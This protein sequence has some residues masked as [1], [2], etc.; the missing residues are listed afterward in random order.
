MLH[1]QKT[2]PKCPSTEEWIKK[3]RYMYTGKHYTI[4]QKNE[5]MNVAAA[6]IDLEIV[7]LSEASQTGKDKHRTISLLCGL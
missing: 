7:I 6:R 1:F 3:M 2:A 5:I 4:I